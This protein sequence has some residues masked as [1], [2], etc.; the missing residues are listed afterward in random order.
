[1][2]AGACHQKKIWRNDF[3]ISRE[4]FVRVSYRQGRT[5]CVLLHWSFRVMRTKAIISVLL[6]CSGN[7][8]WAQ[9][10]P[11]STDI[12]HLV[13]QEV[14][15]EELQLNETQKQLAN[16]LSA[17]ARRERKEQ[18]RILLTNTEMD[19][20]EAELA[21]TDLKELELFLQPHQLKRLNELSIQKRIYLDFNSALTTILADKLSLT[22][23]QK[24]KLAEIRREQL[25][26]RTLGSASGK[27][28]LQI[29]REQPAKCLQV[30]TEEQK[31]ILEDLQGKEF[32]VTK[33]RN[34][35]IQ[36]E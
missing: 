15:Q 36:D 8:A 11:S 13:G 4:C 22:D 10:S 27:T 23:D 17:K 24:I 29:R 14:V 28:G 16:Q 25:R 30:L 35:R 33:I 1:L 19:A 7:A 9:P 20:A 2:K 3:L 32:D 26:A 31:R 34:F 21:K 6:L 5:F 12:S 18:S